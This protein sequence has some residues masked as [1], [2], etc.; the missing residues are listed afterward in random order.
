[1]GAAD[2]PFVFWTD[3][4]KRRREGAGGSSSLFSIGCSFCCCHC[5]S[6]QRVPPFPHLC[7]YLVCSAGGQTRCSAWELQPLQSIRQAPS[8]GG[9]PGSLRG[10]CSG[11][12]RVWGCGSAPGAAPSPRRPPRSR[13]LGPD[14]LLAPA[15]PGN[16]GAPFPPAGS[17]LPRSAAASA[18]LRC[19]ASRSAP[20]PPHTFMDART[21]AHAHTLHRA[22]P[23][24]VGTPHRAHSA[25]PAA[26]TTWRCGTWGHGLTALWGWA[27]GWVW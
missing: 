8:R 26:H 13:S 1:M 5:C 2:P 16:S 12:G 6:Q 4:S 19:P 15:A 20:A 27:G 22:A 17:Y 25:R 9:Q 18:P 24:F 10:S 11:H 7:R 3:G 23:A 14:G 21:P